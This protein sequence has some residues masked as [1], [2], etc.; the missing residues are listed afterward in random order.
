MDIM[1][2]VWIAAA[3]VFLIV[4]AVTV[5]LTSIWLAIGSLGGL[6][7]ALCHG[8]LW[9]QIVVFI[10]VTIAALVLTKPFVKKYV[11]AK[12]S[13]TNAD[14]LFGVTGLVTEDIDNI[15]NTGTVSISGQVWTAR[16]MTGEQLT[17][18]TRVKPVQI[19]GVKLIVVK[20]QTLKEDE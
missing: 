19:E 15:K 9:L 18:G 3:A 13:P 5:G 6:V 11:D 10:V 7:V 16:S 2:I 20:E 1:E 4:E 12:K 17:A 14:R 8:E